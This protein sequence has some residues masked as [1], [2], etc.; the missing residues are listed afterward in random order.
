MIGVVTQSFADRFRAVRARFGPLVWGLDPSSR[1]WLI[2]V[3]SMIPM[4]WTALWTSS[5]V[6]PAKRSVW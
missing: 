2:G 1:F 3:L 5:L 6:W 4:G